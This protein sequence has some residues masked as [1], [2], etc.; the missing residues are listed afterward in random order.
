MSRNEQ[1]PRKVE[2]NTTQCRQ[3]TSPFLP[4]L[5][6]LERLYLHSPAKR[7]ARHRRPSLN[8]RRLTPDPDRPRPGVEYLA[9]AVVRVVELAEAGLPSRTLGQLQEM[10]RRAGRLDRGRRVGAVERLG[11]LVRAVPRVAI[12]AA[13]IAAVTLVRPC[14]GEG[15]V[16]GIIV[17]GILG[18]IVRNA[19]PYIVYCLLN[20][21]NTSKKD[22]LPGLS[23]RIAGGDGVF[24]I[25]E[26]GRVGRRVVGAWPGDGGVGDCPGVGRGDGSLKDA[27][28]DV[29]A[30]SPE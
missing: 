1:N 18:K 10:A 16:L 4:T 12:H 29:H 28:C 9:L 15:L 11:I 21:K 19:C 6:D 20:Y 8:D 3:T 14:A 13:G 27:A 5:Q 26:E 30:S 23:T 24:L 2:C 7:L 17:R 25:A 22:Y